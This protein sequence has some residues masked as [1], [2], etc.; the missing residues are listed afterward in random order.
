MQFWHIFG[1]F[2]RKMCVLG[3]VAS[4]FA[5]IGQK[6]AGTVTENTY[7]SYKLN[8]QPRWHMKALPEVSF[9]VGTRL[10]EIRHKGIVPHI[11]G[12]SE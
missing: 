2:G 6:Y 8:R 4:I 7:A 9:N 11:H 3:Q 10:E 1:R 5:Q 12:F